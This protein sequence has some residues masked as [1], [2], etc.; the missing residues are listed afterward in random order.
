[1]LTID[2]DMLDVKPGDLAL[3]AGCGEGRHTFELVSR[4]ARVF[5]MDIDMESLRKTRW[6]ISQMKAK[7]LFHE[8]A[9]CQVHSGD[10]LKLPFNDSTFDRIICSE[11]ME[12][13]SD[14]DL[15]CKE[16]VR[17]LKRGGRIAVTVPSYFS[18]AVYDVLTYEYFTSPGGHVRKYV[19][20]KLALILQRNGLEIYRIDFRHSFHTVYWILR[21]VVGLH[22]NGHPVTKLYRS[23]LTMS[24]TSPFMRKIEGF[25][26]YFFPKSLILYA[27][28]K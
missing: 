25:V 11:V 13:V 6:V 4:G 10:T 27:Y 20:R 16:L 26:D 28:K 23:F 12:H 14:D 24:D 5:S 18:E 17:V 3:D 9:A 19:P 8:M 15:A 1:M 22:L 21:C 2:F 7:K